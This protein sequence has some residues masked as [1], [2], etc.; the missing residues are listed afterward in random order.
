MGVAAGGSDGTSGVET[1]LLKPANKEKVAAYGLGIPDW[2]VTISK[3]TVED[4]SER[5]ILDIS[6]CGQAGKN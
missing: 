6:E 5:T 4:S 2:H 1:T 3:A